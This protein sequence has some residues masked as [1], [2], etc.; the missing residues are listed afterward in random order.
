MSTM[1]RY[2]RQVILPQMGE[3]RQ[4]RLASG[5]ALVVGVGALGC[6]S[7]DLLVRAGVGRLTLIDRD[8]V[9]LTNLQRQPLYTDADVADGVPKAIAA[10]RRLR[11]SNSE[12]E[13]RAEVVDFTARNSERLFLEALGPCSALPD[14]GGAP[15]A[16]ESTPHGVPVVLDGTDN[17]EARFLLNDLCV[18]FGVPFFYAGVVGVRATMMAF[19]PGQAC[20]RCILDAP[21]AP[22]SQETCE[23]SGV[24]APASAIAA[25]YQAAQAIKYLAG[26][27]ADVDRRLIEI[28]AWSGEVRCISLPSRRPDCPACVLRRFEFLNAD[29]SDETTL[30]GR[31]AVQVS[32]RGAH[33]IDL[34]SL[35][36][37]LAPHG[38]VRLS[39]HLLRAAI[40]DVELTVFP[41]GRV[42]IRGTDRPELARSIYARWI[43]T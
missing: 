17:F 11:E 12:I 18:R 7:A 38:N 35:A 27:G 43:G 4:R 24:F 42:I 1:N 20:L 39:V 16:S 32:P 8:V 23:T 40:E 2:A 19:L 5:R 13:I 15:S 34:S 30:C 14:D 36:R 29:A 37:R 22:G 26:C 25:A 21:P 28:D 41:D 3:E 10:A 31:K 6:V 9:E 33:S